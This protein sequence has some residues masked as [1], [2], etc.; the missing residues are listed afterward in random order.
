MW[1]R[2]EPNRGL[3]LVRFSD[4]FN[5]AMAHGAPPRNST[6]L[7]AHVWALVSDNLKSGVKRALYRQL[8]KADLIVIE[9]FGIAPLAD[10]TVRD[11]RWRSSRTA[12]T[13]ARP[14]IPAKLPLDQWHAYLGDRTVAD[15]MLDRL[16]SRRR[17]P[18]R[19]SR[20]RFIR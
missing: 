11:S 16:D 13:G 18:L 7:G 10:E 3:R 15:A 14:S 12:T 5:L 8:A 9:D 17:S 4:T 1:M 6:W 19:V 2:S 20:S